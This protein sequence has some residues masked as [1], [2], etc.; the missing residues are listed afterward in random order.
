LLDGAEDADDL[1]MLLNLLGA[2][3]ALVTT[4]KKKDAKTQRNDIQ[5]LPT[6]EAV[7]LFQAWSNTDD[8]ESVHKICELTGGLPLAVRLAGRYIFETGESIKEYLS[9]LENTTLDALDQGDRKLES[10]PVLLKRSL[11]QISNDAVNILGIAGILAFASFSKDVIQAAMPDINI[12]KPINELIGYGLLNRDSERLIISHALIQTY[13]RKN[14][15]PDDDIVE[16]VAEYYNS[17]TR[18]HRELGPKGYALL[19]VERVHIM[20]LMEECKAREIWQRVN[21]LVWAVQS[22]FGI[23][24]YSIDRVDALESGVEAA[25]KLDDKHDEGSHLG[26]LGLAYRI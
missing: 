3:C 8:I 4:R 22:Y 2:C 23:C 11:N 1:P 21:D 19:D 15:K 7:K 24:G 12:K 5:S 17:Y 10:V 26:N 18:E 9:D 6:D 20:R 25:Q 14:H 13:A 16:K